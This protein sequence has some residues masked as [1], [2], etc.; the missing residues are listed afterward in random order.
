MASD[1]SV[2]LVGVS[3][4]RGARRVLRDVSIAV[5]AG[6]TV[7]LVGRSGS[8]KTTL[9]RLVNRLSEPD[10]GEVIVNGRAA[11]SWDPIE[12]RR[13][14]GY[15]IQDAGLFPHLTVASNISIL[16]RLL[17]WPAAKIA[18]R[19]AE[20]LTMVG[21]EPAVFRDRWPDELSGG[22]RQRVGLARA[23]AADPSVLLM[24]E[25]FGALDPIT[26]SELHVEFKRLQS[27]LHRAVV[28]VTHDMAEAF[29]LADRIAVLDDGQIVAC[30]TPSV[31]GASTD[32][33]VAALV[34]AKPVAPELRTSESEPVAPELRRS[35]SEPVAPELRRSEGE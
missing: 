32:A 18:A 35:E 22:Q 13:S 9:L 25:P 19:V 15:V 5:A 11:T 2:E 17:D 6:E 26:K 28:L 30:D 7:A 27:T 34:A 24:D 12:L 21:L 10:S 20:L 33:R 3:A 8:G 29:A 14:I 23:L 4:S 1:T 31:I 16:P